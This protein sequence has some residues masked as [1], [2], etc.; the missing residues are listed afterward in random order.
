MKFGSVALQSFGL[1]S[2]RELNSMLHG[3]LILDKPVGMGSTTAVN[4]VKRI[5]R[6]LELPKKYK[7]GHG[8]TLDPLASGILPIA[9]GEG[10]KT[11]SYILDGNKAYDFIVQWGAQTTTD[12]AEGDVIAYNDVRPSEAEIQNE[13]KN[14]IG[15]IMQTPPAYS[16]L[17]LNGERAYDLAR[18]GETVELA[19][20]TVQIN[21]LIYKGASTPHTGTFSMECGKGTY[22]R[23]VARDLA[24]KL[25]TYGHVA[26]LRRTRSGPFTL[27][28][29]ISLEKLEQAVPNA[30]YN[31][32][33]RHPGAGCKSGRSPT[34]ASRSGIDEYRCP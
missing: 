7:I 16:A 30:P 23:A 24:L 28:H 12:D 11:I 8:G 15:T 5:L 19:P 22:V 34:F 20:R 21:T 13:L 27:E 32:P 18:A 33:G 4:A 10:T 25:G 29:A 26:A 1:I 2:F 17:K 14:F 6:P 9:L 31:R 3:Y